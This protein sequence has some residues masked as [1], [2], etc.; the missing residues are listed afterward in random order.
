MESLMK[1]AGMAMAVMMLAGCGGG[2]DGAPTAEEN[3]QLD[4]AAEMLEVLPSDSLTAGDDATLGN[5][6]AGTAQTGDLPVS[7]GAATNAAGNAQ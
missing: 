1:R 2:D 3:R 5:G 6:E 4:N 7:E